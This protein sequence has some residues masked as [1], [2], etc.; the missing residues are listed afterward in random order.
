[1]I[2]KILLMMMVAALTGSVFAGVTG[3]I[4]GVVTDAK[5]GEPLPGVNVILDGTLMGASTD[6]DGFYAILNVPPGTYTIHASYIGYSNMEVLNVKVSVDLTTSINLTMTEATLELNETITVISERPLIK[7]DEVSTRH[8]VSSQEIEVQPIDNFVE[9]A[10]NQAGVVGTHF[11]GGRSNEVLVLIDGIPVKDPAGTYSG[12]L[13]SFTGEVPKLGIQEMEVSLGGFSAEYGN[14]QSGI[15]NLALQ[16]GTPS[17]TGRLRF[18]SNNFGTSAINTDVATNSYHYLGTGDSLGWKKEN[19]LMNYIYEVNLT[20]PEPI[21]QV[22]L[23]M[24]GAELPGEIG[25]SFSAQINDLRQGY[26]INQQSFDQ[27]YQG[28]LT[29]RMST[30]HKLMLGGVWNNREYDTFYYPASKYGPAGDYPVN[31]YEYIT[32]NTLNHVIYVDD[33]T[34]YPLMDDLNRGF[35]A[36]ET[37]TNTNY[38]WIRTVYSAGMQEYL[39]NL[40]QNTNNYYLVWTHT[41]SS[42]SFYEVRMNHMNT[43]YHYAT[44]DVDDRDQDGDRDEDLQWLPDTTRPPTSPNPIYLEQDGNYWWVLGDDEGYRDQKSSTWGIKTDL[45]SQMTRNHLVKAGFELY[46]H[47]TKVE[48]I[49]WTLGY[50]IF[51][52][53]IWDENTID[54]GVYLQDKIEF[55][56]IIGIFGLRFDMVNPGDVY[57]PAD[58]ANPY[59]EYDADGVPIINNP[60]KAETRY[61]VSP[62]IG[63]SHPI[64]ERNLLHFTYGHYFQRPDGYFL[65]RNYKMLDL[66]KV[67][68]YVGNP[69][70]LPEKTVAYELGVE[71]LFSNDLKGTITGFYKDVNNLMNWE[72][73]V[74]RSIGDNEL[75]VYTNADYGNIKGL[76]FT[77]NMRPGRFFGGSA[78]YTFSVAK[79]RSSSYSGGSSSFT[80]AKRMNILDFDQTHTVNATIILRTPTEFGTNLGGF[81]PFSDWTGTFQF[82]YGSGLPYSSSG[83]GLTNDQRRPWT[84][85]TD[86]KLIRVIRMQPVSL[87]IFLDVYNIFDRKNTIYIGNSYYYDNGSP[88]DKNVKDDPTVVRRDINSGTFSRNPQAISRGRQLRFGI[89]VRF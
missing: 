84:S 66:T 63:I 37:D 67:G 29:Y 18:T 73:Y 55:A 56:G 76:E 70:L 19:R 9:I 61:Q 44:P 71:H 81:F 65:Y 87:E 5:T 40:R 30:N 24:I 58:Y 79:G 77:L 10:Q 54:L 11:R 27:T 12:D 3:K 82:R 60:V 75:N 35:L 45:V 64:T 51:R 53:D 89:G 50:G 20:G 74:A 2:K 80:D 26:Y 42:R 83:S 6:Q 43:N 31:E 41:L 38:E 46:Y 69:G 25:F 39:W 7:K 78:N 13:G 14:V 16:E 33:P 15:M 88:D 34:I 8:Y 49:S 72:K 28:K 22:L 85:T 52:K 4:A 32:G 59:F 57:Y 23:P 47:N 48:N 62:R 17:Y 86:L 21:T 36:A 68:N 1:M